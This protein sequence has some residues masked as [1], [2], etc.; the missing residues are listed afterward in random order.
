ML[1]PNKSLPFLLRRL[2]KDLR[3]ALEVFL[4]HDDD[5][6][7]EQPWLGEDNFNLRKPL[8]VHRT[9]HYPLYD[10]LL[11]QGDTQIPIA[12]SVFVEIITYQGLNRKAIA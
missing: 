7:L 8:E 3:L 11:V 5:S 4:F 12:G 10:Y 1:R 6:T 2:R 9:G